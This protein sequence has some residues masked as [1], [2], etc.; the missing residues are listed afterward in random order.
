MI[1]ERFV[2]ND[3]VKGQSIDNESNVNT[4]NE[5]NYAH[6]GKT[7]YESIPRKRF[8]HHLHLD[9]TKHFN[10]A[11]STSIGNDRMTNLE[12]ATNCLCFAED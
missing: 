12:I 9:R 3:H 1:V 6:F 4:M 5:Q 10:K 7:V 2:K 11:T 8:L